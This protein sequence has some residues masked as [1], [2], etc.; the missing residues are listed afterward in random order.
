MKLTKTDDTHL[1]NKSIKK[2]KQK[3]TKSEIPNDVLCSYLR[4]IDEF[5]PVDMKYDLQNSLIN[6]PSNCCLF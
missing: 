4:V 3:K 5:E 6:F 2:C 1:V